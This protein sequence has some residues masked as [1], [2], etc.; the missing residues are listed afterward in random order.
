MVIT[1][2]GAD[3]SA[4]NVG[5]LP[6]GMLAQILNKMTR[7]SLF[8][9]QTILL[10]EFLDAI[11]SAGLTSKIAAFCPSFM[12]GTIQ[13]LAY[14]AISDTYCPWNQE[15]VFE[16]NTIDSQRCWAATAQKNY[17]ILPIIGVKMSNFAF[18]YSQPTIYIGGA[19]RPF[20]NLSA[21]N[22]IGFTI[23]TNGL[24]VQDM[25]GNIPSTSPYRKNGSPVFGNI[26]ST[27]PASDD[28]TICYNSISYASDFDNTVLAT[29]DVFKN[30]TVGFYSIESQ[31]IHDYDGYMYRQ[32]VVIMNQSLTDTEMQAFTDACIALNNGLQALWSNAHSE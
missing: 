17:F 20:L 30:I 21:R 2:Q 19:V 28:S 26:K 29:T 32:F 3:Y 6:N 31:V 27:D 23:K 8:D 12:A 4:N 14:D 24:S 25:Y 1:I 11:E 5:K 18:F 16:N 15:P 13:E 22:K 7:Y 9:E 10:G